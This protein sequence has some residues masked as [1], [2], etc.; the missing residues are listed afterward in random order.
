MKPGTKTY[1]T[2]LD[3]RTAKAATVVAKRLGISRARLITEAVVLYL[4]LDQQ[5]HTELEKLR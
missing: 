3:T 1:W 4:K 5:E 2:R